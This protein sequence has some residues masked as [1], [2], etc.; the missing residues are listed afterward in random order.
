VGRPGVSLL[1]LAAAL[2]LFLPPRL[3]PLALGA[4]AAPALGFLGLAGVY[5]ALAGQGTRWFVRAGMGALGYWWL[6]LAEPLVGRRLWLGLPGG[7]AFAPGASG[8]WEGSFGGAFDHV[9]VPMLTLGVLAGVA[10]WAAGALLLPWLVRGRSAMLDVVV[11]TVWSA[12]MLAALPLLERALPGAGIHPSPRG[13][14]LAGVLAGAVAVVARA[15]R[16]P[17]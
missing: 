2:P 4:V 3:P 9:L 8:G 14:L 5:P 11:A 6:C 12:A 13:A 10:L 1:V 15:L 17:V 7:W 16:G